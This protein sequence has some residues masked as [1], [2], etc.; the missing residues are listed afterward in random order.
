M[1]D[2][3]FAVA[4]ADSGMHPREEELLL[5]AAGIFHIGRMQFEKIKSRYYHAPPGRQQ[6]WSPLDPYYAILGAEP[7]E[8]LDSIKKKFRNLAM[9]WHP[10]K[11]SATGASTEALRHAKEK[12]QQINEAYEKI[13]DARKT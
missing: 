13:M 11:I 3:L 2:L 7:H 9:K 12:F 4:A 5:Q 8:S 1:L 6:R 10:D